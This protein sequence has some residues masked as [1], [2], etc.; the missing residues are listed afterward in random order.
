[1][2]IR[3]VVSHSLTRVVGPDRTARVRRA[4]AGLRSRLISALDVEGAH[5][6]GPD[7]PA[8]AEAQPLSRAELIEAIGRQSPEGVS[9]R[10]KKALPWAS[11]DPRANFPKPSWTRHQ[12]LAGLHEQLGPRTYFEIGIDLGN[13]LAQSRTRSIGV[14]PAYTITAELHCDVR[15]FRETSDDFFARPDAFD[16]FDGQP[17]ELAFID[18]MHLAEF[19]LRDFMNTEKHMSPGGVVVL[20]DMLP[21]NSLEAY[22]I[23][24]TRGWT[25]DVYKVHEVL[26]KY[27]PDLTLV[28]ISSYPTGSYMVVGLDPT[29]TVLDE[30]YAEIEPTLTTPDP[31]VVPREWLERRTAVD[32][33]RVLALEVWKQLADVH[34]AGAT[35][36][37]EEVAPLWEP[38]RQL[39]TVWE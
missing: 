38:L 32:P 35:P 20:D 2:G 10:T 8:G 23:R 12:L 39:P 15:T 11:G 7:A 27:R 6:S 16:H 24:R 21:R 5:L 26:A 19:V 9:H 29:N 22:R 34:S 31:Q 18:G 1:M 3:R 17:I 37:R 28:P 4:E 36:T 13:S 33:E 30:Q 25:G 14:D